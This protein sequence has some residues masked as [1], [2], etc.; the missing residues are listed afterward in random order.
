LAME[1]DIMAAISDDGMAP[2][3]AASAWLA[4]NPA[5]LDGWLNGVTTRDGGDGMAA[6]KTALGL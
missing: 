5:V 1:N 4:A 2:D 3:A 6:V